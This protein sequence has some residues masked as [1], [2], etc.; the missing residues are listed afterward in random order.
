MERRDPELLLEK[1]RPELGVA[2]EEALGTW[3][4][5]VGEVSGRAWS[6]WARG[7]RLSAAAVMLA[8]GAGGSWTLRG[9]R[10]RGPV[11]GE[12]R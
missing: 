4:L 3:S 1:G 5:G 9:G 2:R 11:R 6:C 10:G 7:F 12:P 8:A